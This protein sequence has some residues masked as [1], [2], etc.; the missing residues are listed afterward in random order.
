MSSGLP[1]WNDWCDQQGLDKHGRPKATGGNGGSSATR[2]FFFIFYVMLGG[3]PLIVCLPGFSPVFQHQD[4]EDSTNAAFN[5]LQHHKLLR[6][7]ASFPTSVWDLENFL[8]LSNCP[9]ICF[10]QFDQAS[11]VDSS[12]FGGFKKVYSLVDRTGHS[13]S[14]KERV[15][16]R[17]GAAEYEQVFQKLASMNCSFFT[18]SMSQ[19][20]P[21]TGLFTPPFQ[22]F[23]GGAA[24]HAPTGLFTSPATQLG[25]GAACSSHGHS[26]HSSRFQKF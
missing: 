18:Q 11:L 5:C 14:R 22:S 2:M 21:I 16:D 25:G 19:A 9:G 17:F 1:S 26:T 7:G 13:K 20:L 15:F 8:Q 6:D 12:L 10:V 23:G 3:N 24:R 4:T